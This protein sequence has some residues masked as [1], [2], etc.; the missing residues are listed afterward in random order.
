M[1]SFKDLKTFAKKINEN[2]S[3]FLIKKNIHKHIH[4]IHYILTKTVP[5]DYFFYYMT[6]C[7]IGHWVRGETVSC[8]I[9]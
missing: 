2:Y 7:N 3:L 8:C 4:N 5:L 9:G 6:R 1:H